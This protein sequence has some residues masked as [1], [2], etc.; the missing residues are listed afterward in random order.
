MSVTS[1]AK[2]KLCKHSDELLSILNNAGVNVDKF[3]GITPK[4][5]TILDNDKLCRK[6]WRQKNL[7]KCRAYCRK[8]INSEKGRLYKKRLKERQQ[9]PE[10]KVKRNAR[11]RELY[12]LNKEKILARQKELRELHK[13]SE[14]MAKA[15]EKSRLNYQKYKN[16]IIA[17]KK[18]YYQKNKDKIKARRKAY[19]DKNKK[20][21]IASNYAY[22]KKRRELKKL[23]RTRTQKI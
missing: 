6:S 10:Y 3:V 12:K 17:R 14:S 11:A 20:K 18:A 21:I 9:N 16:K 5:K 2:A 4:Y 22:Q 15:R 7:K 23:E 19:Y 1:N 8:Y 13:T